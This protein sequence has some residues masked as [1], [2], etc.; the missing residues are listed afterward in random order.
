MMSGVES[1]I[2]MQETK[3]KEQRKMRQLIC[4]YC[5]FEPDGNSLEF[6]L[7]AKLLQSD[8]FSFPLNFVDNF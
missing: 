4:D 5:S 1:R 2:I 8:C 7:T 3:L 6:M